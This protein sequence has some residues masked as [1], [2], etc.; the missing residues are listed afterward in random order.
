M[1]CLSFAEWS[2]S[3]KRIFTYDRLYSVKGHWTPIVKVSV[4]YKPW[5]KCLFGKFY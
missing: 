3:A 1:Y 2:T 5:H 4:R